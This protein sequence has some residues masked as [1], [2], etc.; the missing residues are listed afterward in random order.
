MRSQSPVPLLVAGGGGGLG[1]GQYIDTDVQ[2]AR[3]FNPESGDNSGTS[4]NQIITGE[5]Y[6]G[7][8]GGWRPISESGDAKPSLS[9]GLSLLEGSLGGK[10]C[11][12]TSFGGIHLF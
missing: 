7:A 6:A 8:G 10:A 3:G 11:Y 1:L 9:F 4:L 12:D 2:Q 5:K